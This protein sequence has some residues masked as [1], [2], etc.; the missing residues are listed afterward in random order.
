MSA[1]NTINMQNLR[2][3]A[4]VIHVLVP[5]PIMRRGH[6]PKHKV[7]GGETNNQGQNIGNQLKK[8]EAIHLYES[9]L[10]TE[11]RAGLEDERDDAKPGI[12]N[13][14]DCGVQ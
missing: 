2:P 13:Q 3:K 7:H 9:N 4:P 11:N 10:R 14:Q 1:V 12:V 8:W 6:G 5:I